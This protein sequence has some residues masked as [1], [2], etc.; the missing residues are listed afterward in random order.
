MWNPGTNGGLNRND[1]EKAAERKNVGCSN[2][3]NNVITRGVIGQKNEDVPNF[4]AAA[5]QIY[6][7]ED[8]IRSARNED[9]K[10]EAKLLMSMYIH[11]RQQSED[12]RSATEMR[13][14]G[15]S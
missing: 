11:L 9:I 3:T 14:Q 1:R 7:V 4:Y 8:T 10:K 13:G 15:R 6:D 2:K 12:N 5:L